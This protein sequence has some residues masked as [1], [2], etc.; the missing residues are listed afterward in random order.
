MSVIMMRRMHH[1]S[2]LNHKW[3]KRYFTIKNVRDNDLYLYLQGCTSFQW[4]KYRCNNGNWDTINTNTAYNWILLPGLGSIEFSGIKDTDT[5]FIIKCVEGENSAA[6]I[7]DISTHEIHAKGN[8]MSLFYGDDFSNQ[9]TI[10]HVIRS[11]F[12]LNKILTDASKLILP[13]TN[14]VN[15]CYTD[16]FTGCVQLV[17]PPKVLPAEYGPSECYSNMFS[18]CVQLIK[19]PLIRMMNG[20]NNNGAGYGRQCQNMF[21][22]CIN[23]T[24]AEIWFAISGVGY[25]ASRPGAATDDMFSGCTKLK[26]LYLYAPKLTQHCYH[27]IIFNNTSNQLKV[28]IYAKEADTT[29]LTAAS[30]WSRYFGDN[31][32]I[33]AMSIYILEGSST[34]LNALK[35]AFNTYRSAQ[36]VY[37]ELANGTY[38]PPVVDLDTGKPADIIQL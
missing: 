7:D 13:A 6:Q 31:W 24:K 27:S 38:E 8:I 20:Y 22:G 11:L 33:H 32:P 37:K 35:S 21:S 28:Y 34:F 1:G 4:L 29:S 15:S 19:T 16:M 14:L 3:S 9:N 5:T 36:T 23:L 26:E 25:G 12:S 10:P 17:N 18:G 2:I 30:I